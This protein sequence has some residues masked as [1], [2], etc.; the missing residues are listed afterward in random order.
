LEVVIPEKIRQ[1][2]AMPVSAVDLVVI[3]VVLFSALLAAVRGFTREVLGILAWAVAA[4]SAWVLHPGA[5]PLVARL[6]KDHLGN[7]NTTLILITAIASIFLITLILVSLITVK[8][9]DV[10]LDSR[11]GAVD[12]SLGFVFGAGRG[13]LLC[14]IGW[15]F[16]AWLVQGKMPD[17]AANARTK[18]LLE[19]SGNAL[20]AMLPNDPDSLITRLRSPKTTPEMANPPTD[21]AA[22]PG[23][24]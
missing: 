10:I 15:V 23:R 6:F 19:S 14:I 11:I 2:N 3:G 8:I 1:G 20:M 24:S 13:L 9:S 21:A 17:W 7:T 16:F 5:V 22:I 4:A 12:R 18:S